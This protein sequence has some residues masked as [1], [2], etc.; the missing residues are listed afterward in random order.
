M[1]ETYVARFLAGLEEV[2]A[3]F[4]D[5]DAMLSWLTAVRQGEPADPEAHEEFDAL[6]HELQVV[7]TQG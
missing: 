1:R 6:V 3:D 4:T 5:L 2:V 7:A